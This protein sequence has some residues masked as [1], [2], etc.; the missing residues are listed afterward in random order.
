MGK[1][2]K[3]QFAFHE[4]AK[5]HEERGLGRIKGTEGQ[6]SYS[7]GWRS[8]ANYAMNAISHN[9]RMDKDPTFLAIKE[10]QKGS[11]YNVGIV[12]GARAQLKRHGIDWKI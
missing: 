7:H 1:K 8:G 12:R 3:K 9:D 4:K 10:N 11:P 5:F 2:T 6:V